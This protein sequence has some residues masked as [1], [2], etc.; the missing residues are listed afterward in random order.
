MSGGQVNTLTEHTQ[1]VLVQLPCHVFLGE[2]QADLLRSASCELNKVKKRLQVF[3]NTSKATLSDAIRSAVVKLADLGNY[4]SASYCFDG[5]DGASRPLEL[6]D[7]N[8]KL[9]DTT[10]RL[11]HGRVLILTLATVDLLQVFRRGAL[12]A[13]ADLTGDNL[14][15]R[16]MFHECLIARLSLL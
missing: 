3:L 1:R 9:L 15:R 16:T 14:D 2:V 11:H 7:L 13:L 10:Q 6:G 5:G 4:G 8:A 12:T